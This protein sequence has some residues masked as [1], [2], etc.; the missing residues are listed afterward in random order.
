MDK[1]TNLSDAEANT[2]IRSLSWGGLHKDTRIQLISRAPNLREMEMI[3]SDA[4]ASVIPFRHFRNV[5]S[6]G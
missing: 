4:G 3:F 5:A 6:R 1:W 2:L